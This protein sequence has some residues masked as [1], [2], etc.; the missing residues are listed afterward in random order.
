MIWFVN[1]ILI[2]FIY[3]QNVC[4]LN[5]LKNLIWDG[6]LLIAKNMSNWGGLLECRRSNEVNFIPSGSQLFVDKILILSKY[7]VNILLTLS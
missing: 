3:C 5:V 2:W 4:D 7:E 6:M 1:K